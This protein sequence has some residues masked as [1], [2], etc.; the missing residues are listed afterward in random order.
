[1]QRRVSLSAIAR[2]SGVSVSTVSRYIKGELTLL[3]QTK[4]AI[5]SS[6][7]KLGYANHRS[8]KHK[9]A[10]VLGLFIPELSN[11]FFSEVVDM[12]AKICRTLNI[13]VHVIPAGSNF[14]A[15]SRTL[16]ESDFSRFWA[17][18]FFGL[19][20]SVELDPAELSPLAHRVLVMDE[21]IDKNWATGF[22]YI[23]SDNYGG[24]YL[25]AKTLI[26]LGHERVAFI[27]GPKT[28][29]STQRRYKG[30]CDAFKDASLPFNPECFF[31]GPHS[32]ETGENAL[33]YISRL[34]P[35]PTA[36]FACSDVIAIGVLNT[37]ATLN[38]SVPQDMSLL[39]FDGIQA[40]RIVKPQ[41]GSVMQPIQEMVHTA[42]K[43]LIAEKP[44]TESIQPLPM[45]LSTGETIRSRPT[46]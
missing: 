38:L 35:R 21:R 5:E 11:P 44:V 16:V 32:P 13:V 22:T 29:S 19:D 7:R 27:G 36:I 39:G 37:T 14:E 23:G 2:D 17:V 31:W 3:P 10:R 20:H 42:L 25:A 46:E 26:N 30:F 9:Q 33:A 40:R 12:F 34:T 18:V 43:C 6:M 45:R 15:Q 8:A 28:L 41:L 1:M 4:D 24:A